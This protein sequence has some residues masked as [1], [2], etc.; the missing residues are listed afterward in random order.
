MGATM[1][2]ENVLNGKTYKASFL[3]ET[4]GGYT[5]VTDYAPTSTSTC[6]ES[7]TKIKKGSLRIGRSSP[8]PFD[9][10]GGVSKMTQWFHAEHA[11]KAFA[12]S[13]CTSNVPTKPGDVKG[14][15]DLKPADKATVRNGLKGF[16]AERNKKCK[17]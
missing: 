16:S 4:Q 13:R 12:R 2:K 3:K 6:R 8:S 5:Y 10:E 9:A 11:F 15:A 1:T 7:K 14:Y 17:K